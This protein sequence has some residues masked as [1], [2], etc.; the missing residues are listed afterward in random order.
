MTG[1]PRIVIDTNV[2]MG[3]LLAPEKASGRLLQ[4]W[5]SGVIEVLVSPAIRSE[6]L[7]I[8]GKMRFGS[9]DAAAR[10]EARAVSLLEG[11][12][13]REIKPD[14]HLSLVKDDPADNKFLECAVAGRAACLVTQDHHLLDVAHRAGVPIL[15]AGA[16]LEG[17][18]H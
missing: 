13:C 7:D 11:P 1:R 2:F 17:H 4:L 8:L 10:R 14:L 16:Y 9:P 12:H 6:Y 5:E 3:G 15:T 18:L